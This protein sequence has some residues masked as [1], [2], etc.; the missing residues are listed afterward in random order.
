MCGLDDGLGTLYRPIVPHYNAIRGDVQASQMG[1]SNAY[2][3]PTILLYN[4][5]PIS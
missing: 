5:A 3:H 2:T 4:I 1:V